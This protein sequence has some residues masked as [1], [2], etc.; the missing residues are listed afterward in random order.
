M[1]GHS[2]SSA[3]PLIHHDHRNTWWRRH[4]QLKNSLSSELSGAVGDLGTFIP[5][6]LT[7]T[8]VSNLDLSTTLIFTAFNNISTGLLFGIPMPVQPMKSIAAVAVSETPHLTPSQIA[9]A[10]ASTAATLLIL[11]ASGLMSTLYRFL[12]LPVVAQGGQGQGQGQGQAAYS[13]L[14]CDS[15]ANV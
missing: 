3:T 5:I 10:G 13:S 14:V 12:P 8:L 7:L 4:L 15:R 6:V 1:D 9:T 2:L 11:G